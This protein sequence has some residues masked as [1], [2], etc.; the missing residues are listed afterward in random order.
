[1]LG[2][3]RKR[4][5]VLFTDDEL[6]EMTP[7]DRKKADLKMRKAE[8][9]VAEEEAAAREKAKAEGKKPPTA[10]EEDRIADDVDDDPFGEKALRLPDPLSHARRLALN[11]CA[12]LPRGFRIAAA[13][14]AEEAALSEGTVIYSS[15]AFTG[16][17]VRPGR[18]SRGW[19]LSAQL[20]ASAHALALEIETEAGRPL[21][22]AAHGAVINAVASKFPGSIDSH[23]SSRADA[24]CANVAKL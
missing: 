12:S 22:A 21:A 8:K 1:V 2:R 5:G 10:E 7:A 11:A 9:R 20:A 17:Q 19:I 6:A 16:S 13:A 14:A 4:E 23:I 15:P 18:V 3:Q 24:A